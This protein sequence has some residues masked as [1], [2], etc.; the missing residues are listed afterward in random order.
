MK[1][2]QKFRVLIQVAQHKMAVK[3]DNNTT[4]ILL[5]TLLIIIFGVTMYLVKE[6]YSF[7]KELKTLQVTSGSTEVVDIEKDLDTTDLSNLDKEL[8]D[9][10]EEIDLVY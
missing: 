6:Y 2:L 5:S 3:K 10:E 9:I 7:N 1:S 8:A 4:I